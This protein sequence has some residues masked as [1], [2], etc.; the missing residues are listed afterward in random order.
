MKFKDIVDLTQKAVAQTLGNE[1]MT[2]DGKLQAIE[3]YNIVDVGTSV[4]ESGALDSYVKALLSQMGKMIVE[5]KVYTAELPSIFVDSYDWGGYLERVY[6][7]PQDLIKD[8]MYD[9]VDGQTYDDHKFYKPNTKAK[10]FEQAKTIMC[11]I[12]ITRDQMQMAFSSWEQMNSFLSGIYQNVQNTITLGM[13]AYAHMLISSGIAMSIKNTENVVHLATEFYG[14]ASETNVHPTYAG[15]MKDKDFLIY[16]LKRIAQTKDYMKRY[17]TAFNNG[18]IPTFTSEED[19]RTVLLS[20]FSRAIK[21]NVTPSL[22]NKNDINIGDYDKITSWQAFANTGKSDFDIDTISTISI[23][24]DSNETLGIG[25]TAFL[26]SG[27]IGVVYDYRAMGLCPYKTKVS[28]NYTA[29]ADFW[30]EYHHQL[31]NY[32]LDGN[33]NIV[34]FV[35][36]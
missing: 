21:F 9:L 7:S 20:D 28:T 30:N 12:S 25:T 3:S 18:A 32:I 10:I 8:E 26:Q 17:T 15:M 14:E 1:Y 27:V 36:D 31:V 23:S 11:P 35:L 22:F 6:F 13:E 33:F 2:K 24:A 34:S 19:A 4:L 16:S 5:S 29:I